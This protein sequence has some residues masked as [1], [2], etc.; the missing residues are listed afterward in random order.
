MTRSQGE[1]QGLLASLRCSMVD[2]PG[3][4]IVFPKIVISYRRLMWLHTPKLNKC[5]AADRNMET[6]KCV[7]AER[8]IRSRLC[9]Q[10]LFLGDAIN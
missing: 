2:W 7:K 10:S 6:T 3:R 1:K 8:R 9:T 4:S 5:V